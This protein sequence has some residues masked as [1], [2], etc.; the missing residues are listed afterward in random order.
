MPPTDD[1]A[2]DRRPEF[3]AA[4]P[5]RSDAG[6]R[7]WL[8]WFA[9]HGDRGVDAWT[10][11]EDGRM[12]LYQCKRATAARWRA[13]AAASDS[14]CE[15]VHLVLA[16]HLLTPTEAQRAARGSVLVILDACN[17]GATVE[18]PLRLLTTNYDRLLEDRPGAANLTLVDRRAKDTTAPTT[19]TSRARHR[20]TPAASSSWQQPPPSGCSCTSTR[21]GGWR[22]WA[23]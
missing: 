10:D 18:A 11:N 13:D 8:A 14:W 2:A 9:G 4:T 17:S 3:Q 19:A 7:P 16:E 15:L 21:P 22:S 6:R 5:R 20:W 12:T 23:R 1:N